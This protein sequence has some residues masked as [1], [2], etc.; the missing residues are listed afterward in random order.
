MT[1]HWALRDAKA[2]LSELVRAAKKEPQ[3]ITLWGIPKVEVRAVKLKPKRK[4]KTLL[5][6]LQACP[7]EI[8]I[9]PRKREKPRKLD[10]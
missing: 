8:E 1:K 5:E 7:Y 2:R 3:V 10:L 6:V 9:P 4:P